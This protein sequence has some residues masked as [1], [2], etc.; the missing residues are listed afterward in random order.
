MFV[1]VH[2]KA[3]I[4]KLTNSDAHNLHHQKIMAKASGIK[5]MIMRADFY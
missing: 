1:K 4:A 5:M 2:R 3:E